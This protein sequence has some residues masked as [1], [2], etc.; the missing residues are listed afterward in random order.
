ME[1]AF[2]KGDGRNVHVQTKGCML[3]CDLFHTLTLARSSNKFNTLCFNSQIRQ[4]LHEMRK[5]L[6]CPDKQMG[7][8]EEAAP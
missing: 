1:R 7:D 5:R 6:F 4:T 2:Y 8:G 3:S